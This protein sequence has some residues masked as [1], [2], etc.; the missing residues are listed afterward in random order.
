VEE[1]AVGIPGLDSGWVVN[2]EK[3]ISEIEADVAAIVVALGPLLVVYGRF[4]LQ[5]HSL[6]AVGA[7]DPFWKSTL[8]LNTTHLQLFWPRYC[9]YNVKTVV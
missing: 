2:G 9:R 3:A 1:L 4:H 8:Q 5:Y 7:G 6:A